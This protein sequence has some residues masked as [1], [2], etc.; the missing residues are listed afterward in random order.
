MVM[1]FGCMCELRGRARANGLEGF[2]VTGKVI[3][4]SLTTDGVWVRV[5][6]II[7]VEGGSVMS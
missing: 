2:H 1:W 7:A 5:R 3:M 4:T 6:D